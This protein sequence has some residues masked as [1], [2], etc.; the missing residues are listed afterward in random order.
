M[1]SA[2]NGKLVTVFGGSGFLGRHVVNALA[3]RGY[4]VRAAVRRPDLAHHLQPLGIVGQ[5]TPVQANIRYRQSVDQA[6]AGADAVVNL[7]GILFPTGRQSFDAVQD[8]GARAIAEASQAAG[9]ETLVHVSA[10]GADADSKSAY[11]RSKAA[12]EAAAL[13]TCPDAII[14]RPSIVFGPEDDFFNKF[15]EMAR[16]APAL[17]LVGGGGTRFQPVYVGDVADAIADA[18]DGKLKPGTTYELGGPDVKSF[19]ELLQMM[20]QLTC[21]R[22]ALVP[23]PFGL[24]KTIGFFAEFLPKPVLTR[25][26][27]E[28]LKRDNI[29]SDE[30]RAEGRTLD[31]MGFKPRTLASV[32]PTYLERFRPQG[33]FQPKD[34][35]A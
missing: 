24:A 16:L 8:T 4:R 10:I 9:I 7:V 15:A 35:G 26:Q 11:A 23:L 30:A 21:R 6:V 12:G 20:L 31:G 29:V 27:V 28:L 3:R 25:D 33:Q 14:M 19:A 2:I 22:R 32:L 17:P 18:V 13:E 1:G 34:N 5:V